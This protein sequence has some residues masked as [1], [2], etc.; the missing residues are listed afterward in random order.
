MGCKAQKILALWKNILTDSFRT[1]F[2]YWTNEVAIWPKSML[3]PKVWQ[4]AFVQLPNC[5]C[6]FLLQFASNG[7][8][9]KTWDVTN[10]KMDMVN[11]AF[12][13]VLKIY[14]LS[15]GST[16]RNGTVIK[17]QHKNNFLIEVGQHPGIFKSLYKTWFGIYTSISKSELEVIDWIIAF[18]SSFNWPTSNFS[19]CTCRQK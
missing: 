4:Y 11:I 3:F 17:D 2:T 14:F 19:F 7:S 12:K 6:A 8:M 5:N 9:R 15:G 16:C 18:M 13:Q 10:E 1:C